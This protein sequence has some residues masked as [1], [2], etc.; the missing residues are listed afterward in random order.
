[1]QSYSGG[2]DKF[3]ARL[4]TWIPF[5]REFQ[6]FIEPVEFAMRHGWKKLPEGFHQTE[7]YGAVGSLKPLGMDA[8]FHGWMRHKRNDGL[9]THKLELNNVGESGKSRIYTDLESVV[10]ID[11]R[12]VEIM[13]FDC[14]ADMRDV[15][16]NFVK[17]HMRVV[18]KRRGANVL[19]FEDPY[20]EHI[21]GRGET[22]YFGARPNCFRCYDKVAELK[23]QYK[24]VLREFEGVR[25]RNG[26]VNQDSE[27]AP[28]F[29][30]LYGFKG[31]EVLTRVERSIVGRQVP[32]QLSTVGDLDRLP[33]FDPFASVMIYADAD[34]LPSR[35]EYTFTQY[36]CGIHLRSLQQAFGLDYVYKHIRIHCGENAKREFE[37]YEPFFRVSACSVGFTRE[38]LYETYRASIRR[39]LAA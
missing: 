34:S 26:V 3:D 4:N 10:A 14:C 39:Q 7:H 15:P 22:M 21:Y 20:F 13:R 6:E 8:Y 19:E 27:P 17:Q 37:K 33:D 5:R 23:M 11:P 9:Q 31:D 24:R 18:R 38:E 32:Q 29:E 30:S 2:L 36:E 25:K 1:L 16:V 28:S 12:R 35:S